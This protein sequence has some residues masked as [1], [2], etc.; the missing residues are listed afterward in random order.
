MRCVSVRDMKKQALF[1]YLFIY[2]NQGRR[3][4]ADCYLGPFCKVVRVKRAAQNQ[5]LNG[6]L[7]GHSSNTTGPRVAD[8]VR[9]N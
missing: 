2:F 5:L 3:G 8:S 6:R 9:I 4:L 1:I 7:E